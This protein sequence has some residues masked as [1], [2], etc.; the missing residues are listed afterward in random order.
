MKPVRR[1]LMIFFCGI[2][3]IFMGG[4]GGE[5]E[6]VVKGPVIMTPDSGTLP[7][8][9]VNP[10]DEAGYSLPIVIPEEYLKKAEEYYRKAKESG[11][12]VPGTVKE[13]LQE[14]ISAIGDWEYRILDT[15]EADPEKLAEEL[16]KI[17]AERWECFWVEA[18]PEGKRFYFKKSKWSYAKNAGGLVK[19]IPIPGGGGGN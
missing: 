13:W 9:E 4:C 14:D 11:E 1:A 10:E 8:P 3:A 15:A 17:G 6:E 18:T 7:E 12:K 19:F 16:N 2:P 5:E